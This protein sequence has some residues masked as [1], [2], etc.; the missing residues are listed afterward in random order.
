MTRAL[1]LTLLAGCLAPQA[2]HSNLFV[3]TASERRRGPEVPISVSVG[4]VALPDYLDRAQLVTRE[5]ENR[6]ALAETDRWGEPLANGIARTLR[7]DL[8][9]DLGRERVVARHGKADA[10]I[11]IEVQRFERT[12]SNAIE[13]WAHWWVREAD[14]GA[15]LADRESQIRLPIGGTDTGA[16]VASLSRALAE[17]SHDMAL[18]I[19]D[20][21]PQL[22]RTR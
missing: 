2:D 16:A 21:A 17:M 4:P 5:G 15:A 13:L 22:A 20:I 14:S 10:V 7:L 8:A 9:A 1:L 12:A 18:A 6:I 19:R 11:S 3:L